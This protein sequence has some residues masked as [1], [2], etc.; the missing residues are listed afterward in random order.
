[1]FPRQQWLRNQGFEYRSLHAADVIGAFAPSHA[2]CRSFQPRPVA[3]PSA[4]GS[5]FHPICIGRPVWSFFAHPEIDPILAVH[6][7]ATSTSVPKKGKGQRSDKSDG[8]D[9]AGGCWVDFEPEV[10]AE[11]EKAFTRGRATAAIR[12]PTQT[13]SH[14]G[15]SSAFVAKVQF[16]LPRGQEQVVGTVDPLEPLGLLELTIP[17]RAKSDGKVAAKDDAPQVDLSVSTKIRRCSKLGGAH[18]CGKQC[19]EYALSLM[20]EREKAK[21]RRSGK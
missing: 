20:G 18:E 14:G 21:Q 11:I 10:S 15:K 19:L 7:W 2:L 13:S 12:T 16:E 5:P 9:S 1:M 4:G 3:G 17:D 6:G 8:M